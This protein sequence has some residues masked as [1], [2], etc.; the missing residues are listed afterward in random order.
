MKSF[1]VKTKFSEFSDVFEI[2]NGPTEY[3]NMTDEA[4]EHP[5]L[6]EHAISLSDLGNYIQNKTMNDFEE[7]FQVHVLLLLKNLHVL[8]FL[9]IFFYTF[10]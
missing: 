5:L 1:S 10:S 4:L 9:I 6:P 7:E 3:M 8:C 2:D